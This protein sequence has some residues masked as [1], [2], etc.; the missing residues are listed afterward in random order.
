MPSA[1]KLV[2][3]AERGSRHAKKIEMRENTNN[4]DSMAVM[5]L[6]KAFENKNADV[7]LDMLKQPSVLGRL[8]RADKKRDIVCFYA[9]HAV[10]LLVKDKDCNAVLQQMT[11]TDIED[12]K[13][14]LRIAKSRSCPD[15]DRTLDYLSSMLVKFGKGDVVSDTMIISVRLY[16]DVSHVWEK[17]VVELDKWTDAT[18]N[19]VRV[20]NLNQRWWTIKELADKLSFSTVNAF[21][22]RKSCLK[23]KHSEIEKWFVNFGNQGKMFDSEHFDEFKKL[24]EDKPNIKSTKVQKKP[25]V[26]ADDDNLWPMRK[27]AEKLG[28]KSD[29]DSVMYGLKCRILKTRPELRKTVN[30]WFVNSNGIRGL[31]FKLFKAEHFEEFKALCVRDKQTNTVQ[32]VEKNPTTFV[33]PEPKQ[34]ESKPMTLL[35][36]VA[37]EKML[38]AWNEMLTAATQERDAAEQNYKDV[39]AQVLTVKNAAERGDMLKQMMSANDAVLAAADNVREIQEK[40]DRANALKQ[41]RAEAA[42][43]LAEK[44]ALIVAFLKEASVNKK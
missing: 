2:K 17:S 14:L 18:D 40:I 39:S 23:K 16:L 3:H 38:T 9:L 28:L 35:D 29:S 6:S 27:L 33:V 15:Q 4:A 26:Q 24:L 5:N 22:I 11:D 30:S 43:I 19:F 21:Y 13:L 42:R 12:L 31:S 7:A 34:V 10:L 36:V 25:V 44:D 8:M 41:E 32:P 20:V 37:L 1:I